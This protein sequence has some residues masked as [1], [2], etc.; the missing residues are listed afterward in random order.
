MLCAL[1]CALLTARQP[2]D[3]WGQNFR[4]LDAC[5]P[6]PLPHPIPTRSDDVSLVGLTCAAICAQ[7][8]A[9]GW[10]LRVL[11]LPAL[12]QVAPLWGVL[13]TGRWS[14]LCQA[15]VWQG[16]GRAFLLQAW[17][18]SPYQQEAWPKLLSRSLLLPQK[19]ALETFR[20]RH[21]VRDGARGQDS[22]PTSAHARV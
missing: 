5:P 3:G 13:G 17:P 9:R 4:G 6:C 10:G 2:R 18:R 7:T 8:H 14:G 19:L 21:L 11:G 16:W 20:D 15:G 22:A 1:L 12:E